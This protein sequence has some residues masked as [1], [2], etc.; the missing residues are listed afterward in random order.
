MTQMHCAHPIEL[1]GTED[2]KMRCLP[3]LA[4]CRRYG[5]LAVT[6]PEAGSDVA[7]MRTTARRTADGYLING[8]KTFIT[9]GDRAE[10][11]VLFASIDPSRGRKG[12]T[13]FLVEGQP[14]G[15]QRGA[16]MH[17]M[18][19]R[20]SSTSELYFTDCSLPPDACLGGEGQGYGLSMRSVIKSRVSASAQGVG[21]AV[22][23]FQAALGWAHSRGLL[24]AKRRDA[25][26]IQFRLADMRSRIAAG[27]A[28]LYVT[29]RLVDRAETEPISEVSIAKLHCTALGVDIA[30]EAVDL[31]GLEGD[32][33]R[34]GV[35]RRLRDAK[36]AEIYDGTN[37][38]QRMII[39]RDN[40]SQADSEAGDPIS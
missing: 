3:D 39:A 6:E 27:R 33:E 28:L 1:A 13:A 19:L 15:L 30:T 16:P 11:I 29:A 8:S 40:R 26:R 31:L 20:G 36:V 34:W 2:Q 9:T 7:S 24:S 23:A 37:E 12:I 18:G 14:P 22:G 4:A 38:V 25:Q 21:H 32:F 10:I 35:E 5:A 17:K